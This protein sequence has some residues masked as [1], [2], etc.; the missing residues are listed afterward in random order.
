MIKLQSLRKSAHSA[1]AQLLDMV[2]ETIS[3]IIENVHGLTFDLS[4][5]TLYKFGLEATISVL[6]EEQFQEN[7]EI[8]YKFS[9]D[10]APK[11]LGDNIR[12]LLFQS[13]RELL[14]N[15]IKH[16]K[17]HKVLVTVQ[18]N[19]NNIQ[20]TVN[21]DGVG[22]DVDH[23]E[24]LTHKTGGFGLFNIQ[25]RLDYVGGSLD[26]QSQPGNGSRFVLSAPLKTETDLPR[27]KSDGN[28]DS[29]G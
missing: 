23:I 29:T 8:T 28:K 17:A 3:R 11:L 5:P 13:I 21:D 14:I 18:K 9:D 7:H 19:N 15:I 6:L 20:I 12:V 16:A 2:C 10:K 26:I 24:P 4:S 27:E 1:D 22:F 25:E